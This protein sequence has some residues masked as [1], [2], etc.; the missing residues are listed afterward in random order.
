MGTG[1]SQGVPM[2]AYDQHQCDLDDPRNW[3]TRASIH[4]V[5]DGHHCQVDAGPEF[6]VQCLRENIT[7]IDSFFL[8]HEH[9]D[10]VMGMDDLRRFCDIRED[11]AVPVYSSEKGLQRIREVFPYAAR[12]VPVY[13][14]YPAF[15]MNELTPELTL[16]GVTVR[17][18][19]LSHG[20]FSVLGL[21]FEEQSS[22]K[23]VAYYTDCNGLD[24]RCWE[25]AREV[26]LL[27]LDALRPQPH[28]S[29]FCLEEAVEIAR[30][31]NPRQTFFTHMTHYLDHAKTEKS[32]PDGIRLAYDG[33]RI[34]L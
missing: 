22:G 27:V 21:V 32:L 26:D 20:P 8:T 34:T 30:E 4:L 23:R 7:W 18:G 31:L 11:K 13:K 6:R 10:H 2:I 17:H 1:T 33:L 25:L 16:S 3:R 15:Q 5:A 9:S 29:H 19:H 14:G 24:Q 12:P 28:A